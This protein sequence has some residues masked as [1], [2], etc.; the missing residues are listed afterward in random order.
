L[1]NVRDGSVTA[2]DSVLLILG[3]AVVVFVYSRVLSLGPSDI[4]QT[5]SVTTHVIGFLALSGAW[6]MIALHF[7]QTGWDFTQF[8]IA[9]HLPLKSLYSQSAFETLGNQRLLPLG[10]RYY[11]PFVRPSVFALLFRPL[12]WFGYW[13]AYWIWVAVGFLAYCVSVVLLRRRF[14]LPMT[15]IPALALFY[16][17]MFG[18]ITGQD[19]NVYLLVLL[20]GFLSLQSGRDWLAGALLALCTY[21]FNLVLLMPVLFAFQRKWKTLAAFCGLSSGLALLSI[22]L[23][24]LSEYLQLLRTIPQRTIG[25]APGGLR[26]LLMHHAHWYWLL[27]GVGIGGCVYLMGRSN[28]EHGFC[29]AIIGALL[30]GYHAGWYDCVLLLLPIA[31]IWREANATSRYPLLAMVVFPPAWALLNVPLQVLS[32][33]FLLG[34]IAVHT[35]KDHRGDSEPS[36]ST[37]ERRPVCQTP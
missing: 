21:K 15:L 8:Y 5:H 1:A 4:R 13:H 23:A 34:Y 22:N 33:C 36:R 30:F 27:A 28:L 12:R 7:S 11:P 20:V 14:Q 6:L 35:W 37:I 19:S 3:Y 10:V 2:W 16:P 9:A 25:I 17:P 18:L 32:E 24:P 26:G 29:I 31:M